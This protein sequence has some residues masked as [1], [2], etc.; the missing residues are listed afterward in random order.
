ME[1][2]L[3]QV[4]SNTAWTLIVATIVIAVGAGTLLV[5]RRIAPAV[6]LM[7]IALGAIGTGVGSAAA[8]APACEPVCFDVPEFDDGI[9]EGPDYDLLIESDDGVHLVGTWFESTDG[10]CTGDSEPSG[11]GARAE[12][13]AEAEI[14]CGGPVQNLLATAP[15]G[16]NPL[17]AAD[18]WMCA[19]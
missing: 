17:P 5:S 15:E 13:E 12:T 14:I 10:T 16:L 4:G 1:C 3:A 11:S 9:L 6:A 2:S 7:V 18:L 19:T 8:G